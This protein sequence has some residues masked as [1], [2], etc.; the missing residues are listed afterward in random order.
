M[1]KGLGD[2]SHAST[3]HV[4]QHGVNPEGGIKLFNTTSKPPGSTYKSCDP[5]TSEHCGEIFDVFCSKS[6]LDAAQV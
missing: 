6:N 1:V 4:S 5:R 2:Q 3:K